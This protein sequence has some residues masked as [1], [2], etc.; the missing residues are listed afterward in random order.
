MRN[1]PDEPPFGERAALA[2]RQ[3]ELGGSTVLKFLGGTIGVI[4]IV[5]I[6]AIIGLF[7]LIF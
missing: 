7:A 5:V 4:V 1:D 3:P 2:A 6:L